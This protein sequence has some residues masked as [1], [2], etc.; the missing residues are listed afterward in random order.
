MNK[1]QIQIMSF[2][3]INNNFKISMFGN[4]F[5]GFKNDIYE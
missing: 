4:M 1:Q 5:I 2:N 3:K